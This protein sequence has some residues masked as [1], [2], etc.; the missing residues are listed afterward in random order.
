MAVAVAPWDAALGCEMRRYKMRGY[1]M[2]RYKMQ[3]Y[4][5]NRRSAAAFVLGP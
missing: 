4:K 5:M 1:K 3:R 2:R